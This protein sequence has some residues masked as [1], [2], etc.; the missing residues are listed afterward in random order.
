M[1]TFSDSGSVDRRDDKISVKWLLEK[2]TLPVAV[3]LA[4]L[5]YQSIAGCQANIERA[6]KEVQ[7]RQEQKNQLYTTFLT[8]REESETTLQQALFNQMVGT[9]FGAE[10][11]KDPA[12]RLVQLELL[13]VNFTDSLN[14]NP[15]FWDLQRQIEKMPRGDQRSELS[16]QLLRIADE[17]KRRQSAALT[18]NGAFS[19][20][21]VGVGLDDCNGRNG[22][23]IDC[24]Y[25]APPVELKGFK[26]RKF[27]LDVIER[28]DKNRR[29]RVIISDE[30]GNWLT[31]KFWL[32]TFDFPLSTFSRIGAEER[33][34]AVLDDYGREIPGQA[35]V[36]ILYFP[37]SRSA[38]KDKP[39]IDDL[40]LKLTASQEDLPTEAP[41]LTGWLRS[42]LPKAQDKRRADGSL[43][44]RAESKLGDLTHQ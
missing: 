12:K 24:H 10:V 38:V 26:Q 14:L 29:L 37:G 18:L 23:E 39:Y 44:P 17:V 27:L 2:F 9:F 8:K 34:A 19:E 36:S 3:C 41:S 40:L 43:D 28:D 5:I 16:A 30:N 4:P 13:A 7:Q 1:E 6:A 32:E 25:H 11:R 31:Q 35:K 22:L 33:V 20:Y 15:L 21:L 42:F